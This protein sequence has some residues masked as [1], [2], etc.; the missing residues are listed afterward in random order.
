[1][2]FDT[3]AELE[4]YIDQGEGIGAW[5]VQASTEVPTKDVAKELQAI[6]NDGTF[7]DAEE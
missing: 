1:M 4:H 6:N 3:L 7:F 2:E 5:E